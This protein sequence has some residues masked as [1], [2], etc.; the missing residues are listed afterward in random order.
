MISLYKI[1]IKPTKVTRLLQMAAE[2]DVRQTH[3]RG[4]RPIILPICYF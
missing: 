1:L 2:V 3:H 4:G